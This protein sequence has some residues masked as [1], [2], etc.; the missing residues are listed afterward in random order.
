MKGNILNIE[1]YHYTDGNGIRIMVF[2]KGCNLRCLW[3]SNPESQ[4]YTPQLAFNKNKCVNCGRCITQCTQ[5]A[6]YMDGGKVYMDHSLCRNCGRCVNVCFSDARILY[7]KE[8]SVDE[9]MAE[10]LKERNYF[11]R[12]KGGVTFSGGE[13]ALQADFVRECSRRCR[14]EYI[15]TAIE[16]AGAVPWEQLWHAVEYIDEVLF[17]VKTLDDMDFKKISEEPL[18]LVLDNLAKL[19][20]HGKQVRIRC[21]IIPGFNHPIP[22]R[23]ELDEARPCEA[24]D[25]RDARKGIPYRAE[26]DGAR[27][28]EASDMRDARMGKEFIKK[29]VNI[30]L[31]NGV[32]QIDLLPFHQMGSYKYKSLDKPYAFKDEKALE[33]DAVIPYAEFIRANGIKCLIGG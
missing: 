13:A 16:T 4:R 12:S 30:A 21:P 25:I 23:A 24:S 26:P 31:E 32:K 2:M 29:V 8:M 3:C 6:I 14:L 28:C 22:Y 19:C 11:V 18:Q 27:P 5:H 9:V 20:S 1:R 15:N 17:D 10:I 7:G 33:R